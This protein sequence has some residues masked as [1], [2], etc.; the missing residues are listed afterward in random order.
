MAKVFDVAH[1]IMGTVPVGFSEIAS[2]V[3]RFTVIVLAEVC[4][5]AAREMLFTAKL[6][7]S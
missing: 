4:C 1:E 6:A 2:A 3:H 5:R 7:V